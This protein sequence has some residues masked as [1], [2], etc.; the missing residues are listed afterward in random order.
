MVQEKQNIWQPIEHDI[1]DVVT[2]DI[3]KQQYLEKLEEIS[4]EN[5]VETIPIKSDKSPDIKAKKRVKKRSKPTLA[6]YTRNSQLTYN[7]EQNVLA[8]IDVYL[9][10]GEVSSLVSQ[11][12]SI[13]LLSK[14][15]SKTSIKE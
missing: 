9:Y 8:E 10:L 11:K 5:K 7:G 15:A 2:F 13:Y 3:V 6:K 14:F 12:T 1:T 4:K